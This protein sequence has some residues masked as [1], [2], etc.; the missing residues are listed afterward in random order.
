MHISKLNVKIASA[1]NASIPLNLERTL[2]ASSGASDDKVDISIPVIGVIANIV[3]SIL[4]AFHSGLKQPLSYFSVTHS[5]HS[6]IALP[7]YISAW[8]SIS[9]S[10]TSSSKA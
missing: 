5:T 7:S 1:V 9:S 4:A 3:Y 6:S 2:S 10:R 8:R